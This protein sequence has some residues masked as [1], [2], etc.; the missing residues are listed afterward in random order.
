[1]SVGYV[2]RLCARARY[3]AGPR[4]SSQ[5]PASSRFDGK[6]PIHARESDCPTRE[7]GR[8]RT[9]SSQPQPPTYATALDRRYAV[10]AETPD[11]HLCSELRR[12]AWLFAARMRERPPIVVKRT[13]ALIKARA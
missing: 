9:S 7:L 1:M 5:A 2:V 13:R 11:L 10:A 12:R 8:I 6:L 3:G 4:S